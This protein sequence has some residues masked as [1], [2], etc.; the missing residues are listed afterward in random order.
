MII[1]LT[2]RRIGEIFRDL[3]FTSGEKKILG[4]N[5]KRVHVAH[6]G[7]PRVKTSRHAC[8]RSRCVGG[9]AAE[10]TQTTR[11]GRS[12]ISHRRLIS[13]PSSARVRQ[14]VFRNPER[15]REYAK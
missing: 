12:A 14:I 15:D 9:P 4:E 7:E 8:F 6:I 13:L 5:S 11:R 3:Y 2:L 1:F 10:R